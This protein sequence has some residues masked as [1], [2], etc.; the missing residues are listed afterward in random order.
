MEARD[1]LHERASPFELALRIRHP[2]MDPAQ[3]SR[4]L[5]LQPEHSFKVGE[6]RESLSGIA[7][8]AVHCESYWLAALDP[9]AWS[10][11]QLADFEFPRKGRTGLV[12]ERMNAVAITSVDMALSLSTSHFLRPHADFL[13]RIQAEGG[14]VALIVEM[15]AS[16]AQSFT[17]APTVMKVLAEFGISLELEFRND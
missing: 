7:A 16:A 2:S 13:R 9:G 15:S 14:E 6:P 8:A 4:E 3:I 17:L 10:A 11:E 5:R 12:K 1:L